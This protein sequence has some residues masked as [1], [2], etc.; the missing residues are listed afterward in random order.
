MVRPAPQR[1]EKAL[2]TTFRLSD[3]SQVERRQHGRRKG[4]RKNAGIRGPELH[5]ANTD[6]KISMGY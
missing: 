3:P 4:D 6:R 2:L 5:F 1:L